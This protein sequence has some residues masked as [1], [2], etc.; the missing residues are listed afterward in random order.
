[1]KANKT[2]NGR[3]GR[4][5][6]L[7][8]WPG[9]VRILS[10]VS[11]LS[12]FRSMW[13]CRIGQEHVGLVRISLGTCSIGQNSFRS[14]QSCSEFLCLCGDWSNLIQ[15][16]AQLVGIPLGVFRI[17]QNSCEWRQ[18]WSELIQTHLGLDR[19]P[20]GEWDW[21]EFLWEHGVIEQNF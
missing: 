17:G 7:W 6:F 18:N 1:M 3:V 14:V 16:F 4:F 21:S 12:F 9:L 10:G 20:L 13:E 5:L 11:L 15:K 19:I 8:E 2:N